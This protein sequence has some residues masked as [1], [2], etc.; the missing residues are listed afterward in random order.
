MKTIKTILYSTLFTASL[1]LLAFSC[2]KDDSVNPKSSLL[3]IPK[4]KTMTINTENIFW[5][6]TYFYDNLGRLTSKIDSGSGSID[7]LINVYTNSS[8]IEKVNS[9]KTISYT[10]NSFGQA[11][12][13]ITEE[14]NEAPSNQTYAYDADGFPYFGLFLSEIAISNVVLNG[15]LIKTYSTKDTATINY[16]LNK[17]T[18]IS[19]NN[20]GI[21]YLGKSNKNLASQVSF[22]NNNW[23]Q[24]ISY[25]Y[26]FDTQD[27]VSKAKATQIMAAGD[28]MIVNCLYTYY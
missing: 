13:S 9:S 25:T 2:K 26:E 14:K 28:T 15:N 18:T 19:Y 27:R 22:K 3:G 17:K 10:L 6:S 24:S 7:T 23:F 16:L 11:I 12:S 8:V 20:W 5:K 1:S 21:D 4:I